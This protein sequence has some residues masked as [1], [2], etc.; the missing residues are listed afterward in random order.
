M[1]KLT[2]LLFSIILS[3]NASAA[4]LDN[5]Y[6]NITSAVNGPSAIQTQSAG[7]V[8]GG[9]LAI[10]SKSVTLQPFA[11]VP[12]SFSSSCGN[13]N[14]FLGSF[15]YLSNPDQ[16]MQFMQGMITS[17]APAL[18]QIALNAMSPGLGDVVRQFFDEAVKLMSLSLNSCQLG[19]AAGNALSRRIS[20][21]TNTDGSGSGAML[22]GTATNGTSPVADKLRSFNS[23]LDTVY[24]NLN[25]FAS[26][27]TF[28]KMFQTN[29]TQVNIAM[30][31]GMVVWKSLQTMPFANSAAL[32]GAEG[33]AAEGS[34]I[35][36]SNF[37][38]SITGDELIFYDKDSQSMQIHSVPHKISIGQLFDPEKVGLQPTGD[39]QIYAC[40]GWR[41][42]TKIPVDCITDT[43]KAYAQYQ[44]G[45][46][47]TVTITQDEIP[48]FK[49]KKSIDHIISVVKGDAS[50]GSLTPFDFVVLSGTPIPV[51]DYAQTLYDLGLDPHE[52]LDNYAPKLTFYILKGLITDALATGQLG[53]GNVQVSGEDGEKQLDKAR[54][55]LSRRIQQINEEL[56]SYSTKYNIDA[57][58][59][60]LSLNEM[61][62][63][64]VNRYSSPLIDKVNFA[65]QMGLQ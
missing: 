18:F 15:S 53:L 52:V 16:L 65:K 61:K 30:N 7:I 26:G 23:S 37:I 56:Y 54:D 1:K 48:L 12:P 35:D 46:L 27:D 10:R 49:V 6:S 24:Q 2:I 32:N 40:S 22:E 64:L 47:P 39:L 13:M 59:I 33:S 43:S 62:R 42:G 51:L 21:A 14:M 38:I 57:Q 41:L 20:Q 31:S 17:M 29:Q 28:N 9:G 45:T 60:Q 3:G 44:T 50:S 55:E 36:L 4:V 63:M 34:A 8:S 58:N 5:Y 11:F 25:S 19:Q